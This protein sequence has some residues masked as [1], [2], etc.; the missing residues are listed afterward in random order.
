[1]KVLITGA[2]GFLG[3]QVLRHLVADADITQIDVISR[4]KSTHP[5]PKVRV[6]Q[7]NLADLTAV[8][9][10]SREDYD[11]A[12]HL[13]GLYDF[14]AKFPENYRENVLAT[15]NVISAL[16]RI[17]QKRRAP[18]IHASTYAVGYGNGGELSEAPLAHLP[19]KD[20]PYSYCKAAGE[21]A[22]TSSGIPHTVLRPGVLVGDSIRGD[23]DKT[24][25][26]YYFMKWLARTAAH[27]V[28]RRLPVLPVPGHPDAILPLVP[29]DFAA[30][31]F[32]LALRTQL[33]LDGPTPADAVY[34]L[35]NSKSVTVQDFCR[36]AVSELLPN[37]K[38]FYLPSLARP[39]LRAQK[40]L[41]GIPE[42][43]FRFASEKT[44][45]SSALYT[46][47]FPECAVPEFES[48][49]EVFFKGFKRHYLGGTE[50]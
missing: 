6:L 28:G 12:L 45:L 19:P 10:L 5:A 16:K 27:A 3:K 33:G 37:A 26:P 48:F 13:A 24:D 18:L 14:E 9:R 39:L 31:G 36:R 32:Y 43:T 22:V 29:V 35:F 40:I 1:M 11:A 50:P 2:T 44:A 21:K 41:T 30:K 4:K 34:G 49:Q 7:Q 42:A 47:A 38:I 46:A 15:L 17:N 23:F 25:G 20:I 8:E